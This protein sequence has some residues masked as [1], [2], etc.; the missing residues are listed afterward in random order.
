MTLASPFA[1]AGPAGPLECQLRLPAGPPRLAAVVCHPHPLHGGTMHNHV[2]YRLA[3]AWRDAQVAC[4]R[5]NFRGVGRSTGKHDEGRGE[6]DDAGAALDFIAAQTPDVPLYAS[7]FSFGSRT[8][9][10]LGLSEPR[11]QKLLAV[12]VAVDLFDMK[13]ITELEQPIAFVHAEHDEYGKLE[14]LKALLRQLKAKHE[15]FVVPGSDHLANGRLDAFSE[16]AK[17]AVAWLLKA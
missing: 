8:A 5:F 3:Q 17:A 10:K 15:L 2:T 4:V 7:G 16:A 11:V 13:F 1:L 9:L 6:V 14:N 12:G